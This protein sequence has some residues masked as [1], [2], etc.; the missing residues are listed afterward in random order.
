MPGVTPL[1]IT[2]GRI[3]RPFGIKNA[4]R[5]F[6]LHLIGKTGTGKT[7][8]MESMARADI[9]SGRGC[10]VLDPHGDLAARLHLFALASGRP[11][12]FLDAADSSCPVGYNPLRPVADAHIPL[13]VSGLIG[14]FRKQFPD[15][16]G[17]RMEH[18]LRATLY[19]ILD[20]GGGTLADVLHILSDKA[21]RGDRVR[22]ARNLAVREFWTVEYPAYSDRYRSDGAAPIQNKLGSFLLD[23]RLRRIVLEP[24]EQVSPR[25][26][27][28]E[29][30]VLIVN[31]AKGVI[32]EDASALLGGLIVSTFG[33]AAHSRASL[34]EEERRAFY[35]FIDE[36]Q[37][38]TTDATYEMLS[39]VR[40]YGLSLTLAHQHL[41]QLPAGAAAPLLGNVGTLCVFRSG[42]DDAQVLS[43][44]LGGDISPVDIT[45][46]P[47]YH[48][49]LRLLIDG[50]PCRAFSAETK[51]PLSAP[52]L[53]T[54]VSRC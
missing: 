39:E 23:P 45:Q 54:D 18:L 1:G 46:L 41:S 21:V 22:R 29:G 13:A 47:N 11:A 19:L 31:L 49:Y 34:K 10:A 5:V 28:D 7:S 37:N 32:G 42:G 4:D 51:R 35:L 26:V 16:W 15:A 44:E 14:T 33:L 20:T 53:R 2:T 38:Y 24:K 48:L 30:G 52:L 3:A 40:K 27:M 17:V 43:R 36:F 50:V 9:A 12:T 6:H 8:L 25:R